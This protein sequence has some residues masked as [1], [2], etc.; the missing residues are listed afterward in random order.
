MNIHFLKRKTDKKNIVSVDTEF[1]SKLS[2]ILCIYL[3]PE[4]YV[5]ESIN[6]INAKS[7]YMCVCESKCVCVCVYLSLFILFDNKW[8][9]QYD[10]RFGMHNHQMCMKL[11]PCPIATLT[12][13]PE[14][15]I[16]RTVNVLWSNDAKTAFT[17]ASVYVS[18][19]CAKKDI[20][21]IVSFA[22]PVKSSS[23]IERKEK[24]AKELIDIQ[25]CI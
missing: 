2:P 13:N 14:I 6:S 10:W 22:I 20:F 4:K 8:N 25:P 12:H 3:K 23:E 21:F 17:Y 24:F 15:Y 16:C 5:C 7:E 1:T 19:C 9:K 18:I 11:V